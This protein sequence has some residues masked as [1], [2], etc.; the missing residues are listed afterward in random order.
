M[1][2]AFITIVSFVSI[3]LFS[4]TSYAAIVYFTDRDSFNAALSGP[5]NYENFENTTYSYKPASQSVGGFSFTETK[6]TNHVVLCQRSDYWGSS[7]EFINSF[8]TD[9]PKVMWYDDNGNSVGTFVFSPLI[10]AVGFDI[11]A[12][13]NSTIDITGDL[14][15]TL[16]LTANTH[17]FLGAID[18]DRTFST[19]S[20]TDNGANPD[21][22]FDSVAYGTTSSPVPIPAAAWLLGSGLLGLFGIRRK[23]SK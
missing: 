19:F 3:F 1:K 13:K 5:I 21:I 22:G 23:F 7:Y 8:V 11:T 6:G 20:I 16:V 10:N 4:G 18:Y 2:R 15:Y 14:S 12:T 9:G 17:S